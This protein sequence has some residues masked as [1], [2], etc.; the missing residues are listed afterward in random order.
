MSLRGLDVILSVMACKAE[1]INRKQQIKISLIV[2]IFGCLQT[3][4]FPRSR[5]G[6]EKLITPNFRNAL[7][8]Q[9]TG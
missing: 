6:P 9:R 3:P 2:M 5:P 7:L 8:N 1:F 4:G